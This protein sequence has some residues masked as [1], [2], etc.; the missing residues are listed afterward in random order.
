MNPEKQCHIPVMVE[1][2]LRLLRIVPDGTYVDATAGA[3][4]HSEQIA[5]RLSGGRLI[6]LDR[7]PDAVSLTRRR[8]AAYT[9]V[10]VVKANYSEILEVLG[11]QGIQA[12]D[13]VLIDAG[14]SSLQLDTAERGFSFQEDA[15]LDMRMDPTTGIDAATWLAEASFAEIKT[16]LRNYGDVGPAGRIAQKIAERCRENRMRRTSDLVAA[17]REAL[18][19][20]T[21]EP[22]EIRTSFMAIRIAVNEELNFL[23]LGLRRAAQALAVGGRL[24]VIT[25]HSGEDR[26]AKQVFRELTRPRIQLYPDGRVREKIP[27]LLKLALPGPLAPAPEEVRVNLRAKSAKMRAVERICLN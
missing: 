9:G 6:S 4:G 1:E 11:G 10:T 14:T 3:G 17:I 16:V 15:A 2:A 8:L 12:V 23:E 18:A 21:S 13:G 24:V 27:P 5:R 22:D 26:V 19:F 20:V 25:F 7:D